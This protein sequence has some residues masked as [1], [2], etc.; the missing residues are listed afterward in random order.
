M[1]IETP[2][3]RELA[4]IGKVELRIA[5][6]ATDEK[7]QSMLN[8]YLAPLLLKLLSDFVSVR[9]RVISVCQHINTR[10][11]LP[12]IQIPVAVLLKQFKD[13]QNPLVRHF[14]LLYIQQG[15]GRL[16]VNE[17]LD[18][19]PTLINGI[20][21]NYDESV[22]SAAVLFNLLLNLLNSMVFPS[23]GTADDTALRRQLGLAND[24]QDATFVAAWLG[25]TILFQPVSARCAG[26]TASE[27][28]FL[29]LNGK[30]ETWDP[31]AN[32]GMNLLE[33]KITVSKFLASG[34]F[35]DSE[36]Y[37]PAVCMS[38]DSNAKV[39]DIGEDIL[40][41]ATSAISYEDPALVKNLYEIYL[42][43]R[44]ESGSLPA[45]VSLQIKILSLL[46]KS[47]LALSF[48]KEDIQ[49]IQEALNP[50]TNSPSDGTQTSTRGLEA[51]RL[52]SQAFA[53]TNW[54]A[55]MS[56]PS[57]KRIIAPNLTFQLRGYIESQGWPRPRPDKS[58][59]IGEKSSRA[60]AYESIGL[61]AGACPDQLLLDPNLNV[62]RWL[63]TS[64]SEDPCGSEV[65]LSI[66]QALSSVLG[67]FDS[68]VH[69]SIQ[70][71][72]TSLF[73]HHMSLDPTG[74]G[75][76]GDI[77][78]STRFMAVKFANR[79]LPYQ[80]VKARWLNIL[81][82]YSDASERKEV[83]EEGR[84]GLDPFWFRMLNSSQYGQASGIDLNPQFI[85]PKFT[86]LISSFFGPESG[87][88][89]LH[90][91]DSRLADAYVSALCFCRNILL[92][93]VLCLHHIAPMVDVEWE[94]H[95]SALIAN[96]E[97]ARSTLRREFHDLLSADEEFSRALHNY[98]Q[99]CF[100]GC[101][102]LESQGA[103]KA[104]DFIVELFSLI[105]R[106]EFSG[107][108]MRIATLKEPI[109]SNN[110][111]LRET[112][113][114]V[115]GLLASL[116]S[117]PAGALELMIQDFRT[118]IIAWPQ[119]VGSQAVQIHG[120][121]L[122]TAFLISRYNKRDKTPFILTD[123]YEIFKSNVLNILNESHDKLL[124][125]AVLV[126][127]ADLAL[128]GIIG[129]P[130]SFDLPELLEKLGEK[131]M[132]G[133]EKAILAL[134]QVSMQC[135]EVDSAE[136]AL[137]K[138]IKCLYELHAIRG[139][140][141]QF[142][143]GAAL[144]CAASGLE[145]KFLISAID[146]ES[147]K[148]SSPSRKRTLINVMETV[149]A[150]CKTSKP[151]LRQAAVIW[152]LCLVQYCGHL[153]DV[154]SRL[155]ACQVAFKGFLADRDSLNQESASRGLATIYEIGNRELKHELITDL[156][157]SFTGTT[158]NLTGGK[159]SNDTELFDEGALSTGDGSITTY[160]DIMSL[161][162]EIGDS[163]LVYRFMSLASNNAIWSSRAAFGRF[164][165][166]KVL[167]DA[168]T[169]SYVAQNPKLY[170]ALFRYRFDPNTNVR[171]SMND[172]WMALV[173]N[174]IV[175]INAHFEFIINDLVKNM[176]GKEWRVRQAS[177]AAIADLLQGRPQELYENHLNE[178]WSVTFKVCDDI[179]ES[180]RA[181]A[182]SLARVLTR[183]LIGGLEVGDSSAK[184][185]NNSLSQ[186]LPFLLG[187]SGLESG[188]PEVQNFS[189]KTIIEII[190]KSNGKALQPF[191]PGLVGSLLAL[192]S[193][194]EP[195]M[196]NY[197][198]LNADKYGVTVEELDDARLK[199]IRGS[200][201]LEAI[202]R[203][204][205][206]LDESSI[207][208]LQPHLENA[209]KTA[210]GLPSKV[211]C[212]RV[213]VS[214]STR[215]N[216]IF[217]PYA[218]RSLLL[219]QKQVL[220]QN[221]T[222][223][224]SYA[225]SCGHLARLASDEILFH[226]I[227]YCRRLYFTSDDD[228]HRVIAGDLIHAL[229]KHATDRFSQFAAEALPFIFVAKHDVVE[230]AR[231]R[232][233][234]TWDESVGGS[235]AVSLYLK[236][237]IDLLS[238]SIDSNRW[239]IKHASAYAISNAVTFSGTGISD[240]NAH[241]MWQILDKALSAKAW[242]GKEKTLEALILLAKHS[243]LLSSDQMIAEQ[244]KRIVIREVQ[245]NNIVYRPHALKCMGSFV[246]LRNDVDMYDQV[247]D[248]VSKIVKELSRREDDMDLSESLPT[249]EVGETTLVTA[250]IALLKAMSS[251]ASNSE[252]LDKSMAQTFD[253]LTLGRESIFA[254]KS[255]KIAVYENLKVFF[256]KIQAQS[257][258][259][260]EI[261][262]QNLAKY[263]ELIIIA[264]VEVEQIRLKAAE[265]A[266]AIA[267]LIRG[268]S[269]LNCTFANGLEKLR[270]Q[271][272]SIVV[273]EKLNQASKILEGES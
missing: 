65:S 34:A 42:G 219:A 135:H 231:R 98:L 194:I 41:R 77:I 233:E 205:D 83:I 157:A 164:G 107:L 102:S 19:L 60:I 163:S 262:E 190:K 153:P 106:S 215:Q 243:T 162:A 129:G 180:V 132:E 121:I 251:H 268:T 59:N 144:T 222:V 223:S 216:F 119:A 46:C 217:K 208:Q 105:P 95:I 189:R 90:L 242:E 109:L 256:E 272:R 197:V 159:V 137:N 142:T 61:L 271:E 182:M 254:S 177:C 156:V 94:Q 113:S 103:R 175:T 18:L 204:L 88:D 270:L 30:R 252:S 229:S 134:G 116:K 115:F 4:L 186:V 24:T 2:E 228:R 9:N 69:P 101:I 64:L 221:D 141:L 250:G 149:L 39:S 92:H 240:D 246:E 12:T 230:K 236:E 21:D 99:A 179:K 239:S 188:A 127:I 253:L 183:I 145:T 245:R 146:M 29:Q 172:I 76:S 155:K 234:V 66:E 195:E 200:K 167:S 37:L 263:A 158:S 224:S 244:M 170:S 49:I 199:H 227:E 198:H 68:N 255:F 84:R 181:S 104:G 25:R 174:P 32:G 161:A 27:C 11:K 55:R 184:T 110:K 79:C 241:L 10:I 273:R 249:K 33:T 43:T 20:R 140:E 50:D 120:A 53:F 80:N 131:S 169:H 128:Y 136:S 100:N 81:A 35:L 40:K 62:L 56:S 212:S 269:K 148:S 220:D 192:L 82:L 266:I 89:F 78:R 143:V 211:G 45:R 209:I 160:K 232:F 5:V 258:Q 44:G 6:A 130:I 214:L 54:I 206:F 75:E 151:T 67:A 47:K 126:A 150:D 257:D 235:R 202:E 166:G 7:L 225:V 51:S 123:V 178:I 1:S 152:L 71:A 168:S 13:H 122:A 147:P 118:K 26:L 196:I 138:G 261:R 226:H 87:W 17:R 218:D 173:K 185:A 86:P 16:P 191:V 210:I 260:S 187:P 207:T 93:Q 267:Y 124:Q 201:M 70:T 237:I 48:V 23:R 247:L 139:P 73:S 264:G 125:E 38:A 14:D 22:A 91:K 117:S 176:L 97:T 203:C 74:K 36:R 72:L 165:L 8:T 15:I 85:F 57:D 154:Q 265:V 248:I 193:S 52:R 213:L 112:S 111:G 31:K 171:T 238:H 58:I 133:N 114:R 96:D 3:A 63:F 28:H 259:M 108:A